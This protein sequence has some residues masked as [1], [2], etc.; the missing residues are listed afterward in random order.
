MSDSARQP[1]R[2]G[3]SVRCRP[4][5]TGPGQVDLS[6]LYRRGKRSAADLSAPCGRDL[7]PGYPGDRRYRADQELRSMTRLL[8]LSLIFGVP[9]LGIG[10]SEAFAG[11][12]PLRNLFGE[13][14]LLSIEAILCTPVV[15][16][17]GVP[18]FVR[19]WRS[20]RTRRLN[21]YTLIG[22]GVGA[23]L[24]F[25]SRGCVLRLVGDQSASARIDRQGQSQSAGEGRARSPRALS[26]RHDRPLLR[27]RR[28]DRHPGPARASARDSCRRRSSLAIRKL[29]PLVPKTAHVVLS[30]GGEEERPLDQ[31]QP[32]EL[33]RVRPGERIPVDG[34]I[35]QGSTTV[36]ESMLTG[37]PTH[38]VAGKG[39]AFWPG[40]KTAWVR[41]LSR[42]PT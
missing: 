31:V 26:T 32:G 21:L 28:D 6:G 24:R 11:T 41:L 5:R 23:G 27:K 25:Q 9:L 38:P 7:V 20:I 18:F 22:L 12:R 35:R 13:K 19:A 16:I 34:V 3:P 36:D 1:R 14:M 29:L 33:V 40:A 39:R 17:A 8:W 10:I 2:W 4:H 30:D 42:R 37:E 15:V